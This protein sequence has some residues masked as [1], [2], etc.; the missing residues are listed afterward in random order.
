M[1]TTL[2]NILLKQCRYTAYVVQ[3]AALCVSV[4]DV[5][6]LRTAEQCTTTNNN[7]NTPCLTI[8]IDIIVNMYIDIPHLI[9]SCLTLLLLQMSCSLFVFLANNTH[10]VVEW[11]V[12]CTALRIIALCHVSCVGVCVCVWNI[13]NKNK[14]YYMS[15]ILW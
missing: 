9:Y 15:Y 12:V 1:C 4:Q 13:V 2:T 5:S 3:T 7:I 8:I 14:G 6:A 11:C 10:N